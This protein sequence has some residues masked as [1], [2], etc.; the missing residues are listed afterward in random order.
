MICLVLDDMVMKRARIN[1]IAKRTR[2]ITKCVL[3]GG[4]G[5]LIGTGVIGI[6]V[7]G[8]LVVIGGINKSTRWLIKN[9]KNIIKKVRVS[10]IA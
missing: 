9:R 10:E 4:F 3:W 7:L 6:K 1:R 5:M 2:T 8:E